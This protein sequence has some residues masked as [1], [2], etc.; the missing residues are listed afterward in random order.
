MNPWDDTDVDRLIDSPVLSALWREWF[1]A[2]RGYKPPDEV[3]QARQGLA[4]L[5]H[6]VG[7]RAMSRDERRLS[8]K[9]RRVMSAHTDALVS[10][11]SSAAAS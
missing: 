11:W 9:Y 6:R 2:P 7:D 1:S 3:K 8:A 10:K 5:V 4:D